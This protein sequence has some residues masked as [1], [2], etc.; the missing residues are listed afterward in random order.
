MWSVSH[1]VYEKNFWRTTMADHGGAGT[2]YAYEGCRCAECTAAN[3]ARA[4]RRRRERRPEDYRGEHGTKSAYSN[5]NCRCPDCTA[6]NS[7]A[8]REYALR[9]KS[10]TSRVEAM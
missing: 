10:L 5:W 8:S 6:A 9:R 4:T 1:I 3:T 7:V 2:K